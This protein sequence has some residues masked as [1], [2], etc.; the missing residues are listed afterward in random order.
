[1]ARREKCVNAG[2]ILKELMAKNFHDVARDA[3]PQSFKKLDKSPYRI[4]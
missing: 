1:M 2:Q 3:K 4:N